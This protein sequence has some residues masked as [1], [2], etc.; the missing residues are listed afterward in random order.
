MTAVFIT[1]NVVCATLI[2][3]LFKLFSIL[4][5]DTP[6]ALVLNY[7]IAAIFGVMLLPEPF[8]FLKIYQK[9]WFWISCILGFLFISLFYLMALISQKIGVSAASVSSKMSVVIPVTAA[10]VLYGDDITIAKVTG[11]I[12]ALAG[13]W[14]ATIKEKS[15]IRNTALIWLPFILFLGSG[16]L[17]TLL[18]FSQ[19]QLVPEHD[20]MLFIPSIFA[21]AFVTGL[22]LQLFI[23]RSIEKQAPA[24]KTWIGGT[25]LGIINYGS[26]FFI[27]NALAQQDVES[28]MVFP[29]ANMGV[30]AASSLAGL[31][32]FQERMSG[33]N[34]FGILLSI[35]AIALI[36]LI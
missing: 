33:K 29:V 36:A 12:L 18:K 22:L 11:I 13:I 17:D 30:V 3:V 4:R 5:I 21:M 31:L 34:W 7:L 26:I 20:E 32:M 24:Y 10:F 25:L 23:P 28:S 2:F 19:N 16:T 8:E 35:A 15:T 14:L 1:L 6:K 27:Y 9:S